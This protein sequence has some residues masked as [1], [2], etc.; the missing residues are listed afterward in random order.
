MSSARSILDHIKALKPTD[1][2]QTKV[3]CEYLSRSGVWEQT[4]HGEKQ[5]IMNKMLPVAVYSLLREFIN[6]NLDQVKELAQAD[7]GAYSYQVTATLRCLI[8]MMECVTEMVHVR[9]FRDALIEKRCEIQ[10][11]G[12][13][14][15]EEQEIISITEEFGPLVLEIQDDMLKQVKQGVDAC[16]VNVDRAIETRKKNMPEGVVTEASAVREMREQIEKIESELR[17]LERIHTLVANKRDL[18]GRDDLGDVEKQLIGNNIDVELLQLTQSL[19]LTQHDEKMREYE[20]KEMTKTALQDHIHQ[21]EQTFN[22]LLELRVALDE[23]TKIADDPAQDSAA[24]LRESF[25]KLAQF[26][27]KLITAPVDA[28]SLQ[29]R[30]ELL[31]LPENLHGFGVNKGLYQFD[32][33]KHMPASSS[34]WTAWSM[35]VV[36]APVK[37]VAAPFSLFT[38]SSSKGGNESP[39]SPAQ[40]QKPKK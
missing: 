1:L 20:K 4:G 14:P 32:V 23:M 16:I 12:D 15:Q 39:K 28:I 3:V 29:L 10:G 24:R 9:S 31:A 22:G 37:L 38:R 36:T 11:E 40:E 18:E 2:A 27:E 8:D 34:S 26:E 7:A 13:Q 33:K 25:A 21:Y 19:S 5:Q 30:Q 17:P 6:S 35:K